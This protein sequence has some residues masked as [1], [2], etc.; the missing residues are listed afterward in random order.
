MREP[1]LGAFFLEWLIKTICGVATV[2]ILAFYRRMAHKWTLL[3]NIKKMA[4]FKI[5]NKWLIPIFE[6]IVSYLLRL[7]SLVCSF[8]CS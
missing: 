6:G 1:R 2:I 5:A 7:D 4:F 8:G 3:E